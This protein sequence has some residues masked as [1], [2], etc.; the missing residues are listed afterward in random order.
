MMITKVL[1]NSFSTAGSLYTW[2]ETTYGWGRKP[3]NDLLVPGK[4]EGFDD[5]VSVATG[6]YHMLFKTLTGEVFSVGLGDHGRLGHGT[7][8]T[9]DTPES[10]TEL[11]GLN[12]T[13]LAAGWDHSLAL[14]DK[15]DVYSWGFGGYCGGVFKYLSFFEV[16]SP[17]GHGES[18][19]VSTP[20]LVEGF[21]E[22]I[23]QVAAGKRLSLALGESGKV[24]G[25]GGNISEF[26]AEPSSVPI[27]LKE[28]D[29]FLHKHHAHVTKIAS[30][31]VNAFFLLDNGRIYSIGKN[32]GGNL[33]TRTNPRVMTDLKLHTLTKL[34]D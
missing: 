13:Q 24:Y 19:N 1:R 25:W 28:I 3:N 17:L 33:A 2:G 31:G 9:L 20:R 29:Y 21:S 30:S 10:I 26:N 23:K 11:S 16:A 14:T 32:E 18:G 34:I 22:G 4:V 6:P 27:E 15:G 8:T 7:T 5:V 12:I